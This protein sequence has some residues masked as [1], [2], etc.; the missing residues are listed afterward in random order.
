VSLTFKLYSLLRNTSPIG[1][2]RK[3]NG[4]LGFV[5]LFSVKSRSLRFLFSGY[6]IRKKEMLE[7]A[8]GGGGGEEPTACPA[9]EEVR[10]CSLESC[11]H[12]A[13]SPSGQCD[14][15]PAGRGCG[16]G[17]QY[18]T[19]TCMR[20]DGAVASDAAL[21]DPAPRP[22]ARVDC[23]VPCPTDCIVSSW[24]GWSA[25]PGLRCE[26]VGGGGNGHLPHQQLQQHRPRLPLRQ[27]NRTVI[28]VA[29]RDGQ[30]RCMVDSSSSSLNR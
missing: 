26:G 17:S 24:S 19:V 3:T 18:Q 12:W 20:W 15:P 6:Q 1:F 25:C 29:G 27:R 10:T 2:F 23:H 4:A 28:A 7:G 16:A 22:R 30:V 21:C 11:Y 9:M 13:T 8:G 5:F 14:L